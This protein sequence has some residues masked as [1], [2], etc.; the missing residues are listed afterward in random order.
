M[1]P[2][3][4]PETDKKLCGVCGAFANSFGIDVTLV[5]IIWVCSAIFSL[6]TSFLAYLACWLIIPNENSKE[7]NGESN[8]PV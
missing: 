7:G 5:R 2:L 6:G 4:L 1:K 3:R 8:T